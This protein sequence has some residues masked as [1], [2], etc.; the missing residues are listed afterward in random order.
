[1]NKYVCFRWAAKWRSKNK[2]DGVD[3]HLCLFKHRELIG[4]FYTRADCRKFIK[5]NYGYI[6]NRRD[7]KQEPFGW[8][9]PTAVRVKVSVTELRTDKASRARLKSQSA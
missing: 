7:L 5:E 4:V 6:A 2:L 1:M 8:R 3:E 9:V